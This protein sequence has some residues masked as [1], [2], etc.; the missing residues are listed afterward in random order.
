MVPIPSAFL[1]R[2]DDGFSLSLALA[3]R[4][5]T[6]RYEC[7]RHP[8]GTWP[9]SS[10][11][12]TCRVLLF[13]SGQPCGSRLLPVAP[14]YAID[15]GLVAEALGQLGGSWEPIPGTA[16]APLMAR[17]IVP[18]GPLEGVR[19]PVDSPE[20]TARLICDKLIAALQ[21]EQGDSHG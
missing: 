5:G 20:A 19:G 9:P 3:E 18:G 16:E 13:P 21:T 8:D 6:V 2:R 14:P 1:N 7:P 11:A 10:G 17:V 4:L 15:L 12:Q